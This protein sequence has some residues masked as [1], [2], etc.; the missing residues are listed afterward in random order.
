MKKRKLNI[1]IASEFVDLLLDLAEVAFDT[2]DENKNKED[3]DQLITKP[4]WRRWMDVFTEGKKVSEENLVIM[5][6]ESAG[7]K[8]VPSEGPL[9]KLLNEK[10]DKGELLPLVVVNEMKNEPEY[11]EFL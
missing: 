8:V 4:S 7:L 10:A 5:T 9:A 3:E 11:I 1:E 2:L 6:D